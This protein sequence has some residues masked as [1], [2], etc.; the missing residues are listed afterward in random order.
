VGVDFISRGETV[1]IRTPD[2]SERFGRP[3][4]LLKVCLVLLVGS[5]CRGHPIVPVPGLYRYSR[6]E[7]EAFLK[8]ANPE[9]KEAM[10]EWVADMG[11]DSVGSRLYLYGFYVSAAIVDA[12]GKVTLV[13]APKGVPP[14]TSLR[15]HLNDAGQWAA[16]ATPGEAHFIGWTRPADGLRVDPGVRHYWI[17]MKDGTQELGTTDGRLKQSV[18][19][20]DP[21]SLYAHESTIYL[22]GIQGRDEIDCQVFRE[23]NSGYELQRTVKVAPFGLPA[24]GIVDMDLSGERVVVERAL[25]LNP[26]WVLFDFRTGTLT[27]IGET[28]NFGLFLREDLLHPARAGGSSAHRPMTP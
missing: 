6:D 25:D 10:P 11:R 26:Y 9:P 27:N 17:T 19:G 28:S 3:I 13:P 16:W 20:L 21:L 18:A 12:G 1:R 7:A 2:V 14:R 23:T 4:T 8:L 5:G 22:F 15:A 24:A